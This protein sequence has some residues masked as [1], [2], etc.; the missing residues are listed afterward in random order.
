MNDSNFWEA[1]ERVE[2]FAAREPDRRLLALVERHSVPSRVRVLDIGCAG[3]R[4]TELLAARGFDVFAVDSSRAMV[5][6]TRDRIASILGEKEASR[7][8]RNGRMEDLSRFASDHFHLVVALG[9]FHSSSTSEQW[10]ASL[11]EAVRVLAAGGLLL[12]SVFSPR[13]DLSGEGI[14]PV[15]GEPHLYDG[16]TTERHYLVEADVLDDEMQKRGLEPAEPTDTVIVP[17][18]MGRRVT[19]NGLYR[20]IN[21]RFDPPG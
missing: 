2:R 5:R 19:V 15:P 6:R 3:G 1:E 12:A 20:K 21:G 8:V 16:L 13:T 9:V 7:R 14:T 17:L 18:D 4:N 10:T 11:N